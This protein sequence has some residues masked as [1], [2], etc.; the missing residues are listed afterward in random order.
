MESI[1]KKMTV[2][3]EKLEAAEERSR[4]AEDELNSTNNKAEEVSFLGTF[5]FSDKNLYL[6]KTEV[7]MSFDEEVNERLNEL[8]IA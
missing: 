5:F 2:L 8:W 1:K 3:R 7:L 6:R 4:K